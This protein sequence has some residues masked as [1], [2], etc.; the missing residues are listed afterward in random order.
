MK[1]QEQDTFHGPVLM[2]IVEYEAF[3][4]LNKPDRK[5][6]HYILN[7]NTR[8]WV[9]YSTNDSDNWSFTFQPNDLSAISTDMQQQKTKT[10]VILACAHTTICG[11]SQKELASLID[12][13]AGQQQWIAVKHEMGKQLRVTGSKLSEPILVPNNRFPAIIF[14]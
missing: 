4:A 2:Q 7:T 3:K 11:L 12:L 13:S 6:G 5:Y 8:L 1:I 10:F 14:E 9:K